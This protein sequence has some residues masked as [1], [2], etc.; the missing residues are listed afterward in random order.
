MLVSFESVGVGLYI[1]ASEA[2]PVLCHYLWL[3]LV[4]FPATE[5][6]HRPSARTRF[7]SRCGQ[8]AEL[9]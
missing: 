8:E 6:C 4:A 3:F 9:A 1:T 5:H 2:W 7:P